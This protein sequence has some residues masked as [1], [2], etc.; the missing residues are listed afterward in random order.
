MAK[1][2]Q[3]IVNGLIV[4]SLFYQ[5]GGGGASGAFV[6]RISLAQFAA[7]SISFSNMSEMPVAAQSKLVVHRFLDAGM[8]S[9]V[10]YTATVM[11]THFPVAAVGDLFFTAALYFLSG[12]TLADNGLHFAFWFWALL[13]HDLAMSTIFRSLAYLFDTAS[14]AQAAAGCTTGLFLIFGG[15]LVS[16]GGRDGGGGTSG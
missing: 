15:F 9:P 4:G 5:G 11:A 6:L 16:D 8:F 3:S 7:T 2:M 14:T 1:I 12:Y 13:F 10:V